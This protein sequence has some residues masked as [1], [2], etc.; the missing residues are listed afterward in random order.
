MLCRQSS[1]LLL[2]WPFYPFKTK[3]F[4]KNW[5]IPVA[6]I[7]KMML[8]KDRSLLYELRAYLIYVKVREIRFL[9]ELRA[10]LIYVKVGEIQLFPGSDKPGMLF[11]LPINVKIPTIV[12]FLTFIS[13]N[14]FMLS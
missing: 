1:S 8:M 6:N 3:I 14:N 13:R 7:R 11:F 5:K 4:V 12:G 2:A 9:F 10:Y